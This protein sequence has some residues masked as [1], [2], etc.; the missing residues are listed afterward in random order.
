MDSFIQIVLGIATAELYAGEKLQRKTFLYGAILG[1]IL[2]L[3]LVVGQLMNLVLQSR[4]NTSKI[5]G[6]SKHRL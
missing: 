3:D 2:D 4:I 5:I 1:T 6:G